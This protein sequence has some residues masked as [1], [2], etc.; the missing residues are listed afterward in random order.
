MLATIPDDLLTAILAEELATPTL[1][2]KIK[3]DPDDYRAWLAEAFPEYV[4]HPFAQRHIDL[5][6][7]ISSI[8]AGKRNRPFVAIWPR[9]GAKS[10]TAELGNA[11]LGIKGT[12]KYAL[13]I[14][15]TQDQADKH[16]ATIASMLEKAGV[17]RLLNKYGSSKGWRR[18]RLRTADG[19][20]IDALGLDSA[21]R[22]IKVEDK[23]PDMMTFDD[24]DNLEDSPDRVKRKL[25]TI[26]QTILP[27]G[28]PDLSVLFVQNLI[29]S[30]SVMSKLRRGRSDFL[31]DRVV[32]GPF[33]A[34]E[35]TFDYE[36]SAELDKFVITSGTP[37]WEGQSIEACEAYINTSGPRSFVRECQQDV[38]D[39][40]PDALWKREEID[41]N[42]IT[43]RSLVPEFDYVITAVDPSASS[44]AESDECGIVT[45]A[46]GIDGH[47]YVLDDRSLIAKPERWAELSLGAYEGFASNYVIGEGNNGGEMVETVIKLVARES[48]R[49]EPFYKMV[50]AAE[51]K[52]TRA[53]PVSTFYSTNK[54]H[55]VGTFP[56][57]EDEMVTWVPKVRKSPNRIDA[58][59]WAM[60]ELG[61]IAGSGFGFGVL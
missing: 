51:G 61:L 11:Y 18:N 16:V 58:L 50:W 60:T 59:V 35:G 52:R 28:S 22:G 45:V 38:K 29:H 7:W 12:R 20:T 26:T 31:V 27:A 5:W 56:D 4:V 24:I 10:T 47:G 6:S 34:L 15:E 39:D 40:D 2:R 32:S 13:Y 19:F 49:K 46:R 33:P 57:L 36:F 44:G 8:E 17:D 53:E 48:G 3:A 25:K 55:H 21:S 30:N 23:R 54:V 42:R 43:D 1:S 41:K 9:G 14:S 37:S